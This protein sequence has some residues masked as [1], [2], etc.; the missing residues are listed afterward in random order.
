MVRIVYQLDKN[1]AGR[2][3]TQ[4]NW[5]LEKVES[6]VRIINDEEGRMI[7]AKSLVGLLSGCFRADSR[8]NVVIEDENE[9][10]KVKEIFNEVGKEII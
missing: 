8:I 3:A 7:N 10:E 1:L 4:L 2:A 9:L 6:P 5:K